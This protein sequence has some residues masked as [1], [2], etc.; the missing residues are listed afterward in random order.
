MV[1]YR[2]S[3]A[4]A[5]AAHEPD[6]HILSQLGVFSFYGVHSSRV[7]VFQKLLLKAWA[8]S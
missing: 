8:L 5:Y 3:T 6:C 1:N 7:F 4:Q 2:M